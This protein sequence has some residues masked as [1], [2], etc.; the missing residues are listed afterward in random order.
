MTTRSGVITKGS[1]VIIETSSS[2]WSAMDVPMDTMKAEKC[3]R[4]FYG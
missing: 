1:T 2:G 3:H 4:G